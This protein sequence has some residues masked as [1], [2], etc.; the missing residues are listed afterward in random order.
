M[1]ICVPAETKDNVSVSAIRRS[2]SPPSI[3]I[4]FKDDVLNRSFGLE[5][6]GFEMSVESAKELVN[7]IEE[8][9]KWIE[10]ERM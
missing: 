9:I 3:I 4:R 7:K 8:N 1:K 10:K 5:D 6:V 2:D